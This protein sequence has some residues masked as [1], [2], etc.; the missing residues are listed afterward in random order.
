M[1]GGPGVLYEEYLQGESLGSPDRFNNLGKEG[2]NM[3][4]SNIPVRLPCLP[5]AGAGLT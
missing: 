4:V 1:E 3:S 2:S 5:S